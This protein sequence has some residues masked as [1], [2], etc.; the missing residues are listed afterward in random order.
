MQSLNPTRVRLDADPIKNSTCY[1]LDL[2]LWK[3]DKSPF[4]NHHHILSVNIDPFD[5]TFLTT[6]WEGIK[7]G[8]SVLFVAAKVEKLPIHF[9]DISRVMNDTWNNAGLAFH[10]LCDH[11]CCPAPFLWHY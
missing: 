7:S 6:A 5:V 1:L 11:S 10:Y 3:G 8:G 4:L 2:L 9:R